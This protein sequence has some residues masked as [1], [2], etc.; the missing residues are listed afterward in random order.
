M[1]GFFPILLIVCAVLAGAWFA[2]DPYLKPLLD[3]LGG[4][5]TM[6]ANDRVISG[7]KAPATDATQPSIS[8]APAPKSPTK[9]SATTQGALKPAASTS[10]TTSSPTTT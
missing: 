5:E 10:P 4:E 8:S 6:T 9:P 1:K 2:Y 7:S 3:R